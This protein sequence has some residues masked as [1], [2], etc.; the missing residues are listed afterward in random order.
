MRRSRIPPPAPS[1]RPGCSQNLLTAKA[2]YV[3]ANA[4]RLLW[5]A[6]PDLTVAE[7]SHAHGSP[8]VR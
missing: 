2:I 1:S 8:G 5:V 3:A 4:W 6:A 7:L